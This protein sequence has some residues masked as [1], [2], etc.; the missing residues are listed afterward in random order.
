MHNR[1]NGDILAL[2]KKAVSYAAFDYLGSGA[3]F[4][5]M[6]GGLLAV[7]LSPDEGQVFFVVMLICLTPAICFLTNGIRRLRL[8]K[9]MMSIKESDAQEIQITCRRVRF[10]LFLLCHIIYILSSIFNIKIKSAFAQRK[11]SFTRSCRIGCPCRMGTARAYFTRAQ[12]EFHPRSGFHPRRAG[13]IR[14]VKRD[15]WYAPP[16]GSCGC[17]GRGPARRGEADGRT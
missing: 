1:F 9:Q 11:V 3:L 6:C 15:E 5:A 12:R 16:R 14:R 10:L 17:T 7:G 4:L 8:R 2:Q 13:S